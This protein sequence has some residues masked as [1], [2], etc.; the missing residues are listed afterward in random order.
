MKILKKIMGFLSVVA[1]VGGGGSLA[2]QYF[3]NK[4]LL[5]VLISNSIVKGSINVLKRMGISILVIFAGM[6]L[7]II[8]FKIGSVIRRVERE[9]REA[10][11]EERRESE[12]LNRQL[13]KE[14]DEARAEAEQ[15]RKENEFMRQS[16]LNKQ[17][18]E[19]ETTEQEQ[20]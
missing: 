7:L 20:E 3:R 15:A 17:S 2:W 18:E 14:A 6:I 5:E 19:G 16:L 8:Y 4:Q 13:R 10:L 1:I 11:R 9:K 12:E